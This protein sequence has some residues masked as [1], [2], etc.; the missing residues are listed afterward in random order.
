MPPAN[1]AVLAS[2]AA[3]AVSVA[4]A[5]AVAIYESPEVRRYAEDV[6]RKIAV[7]LYSMGDGINPP[8]SEPLFNRPEDLHG[9]LQSSAEPGVDA[10]EE[11]RRR[12]RE[13]LLYWNAQRLKR[14]QEKQEAEDEQKP[15]HDSGTFDGFLA[16]D[17]SGEEGS[18]VYKSGADTGLHH[19][20]MRQRGQPPA[21]LYANPFADEHGIASDEMDDSHIAPTKDETEDLYSATTADEPRTPAPESVADVASSRSETVEPEYPTAGQDDGAYASIQA[22][23][24]S[25]SHDLYSPM[26][27]TPAPASEPELASDDGQLTPTDSMSIIDGAEGIEDRSQDGVISESD[28]MMTPS[29]WSEVGSVI[30]ESDAPVPAPAQA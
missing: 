1:H 7:A 22:W 12:Q 30:S 2:G 29:S 23:A 25:S 13:E 24:Q 6:R 5:A 8:Q 21:S 16:R 18:Y 27:S 15:R 10:D 11:T 20:G 3:V 28:G 19:D 26:P 14:E 9:F 17:A 4:V